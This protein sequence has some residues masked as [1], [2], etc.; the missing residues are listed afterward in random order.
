MFND[1]GEPLEAHPGAA[2]LVLKLSSTARI[3]CEVQDGYPILAITDGGIT[4]LLMPFGPSEGGRVAFCDN[5]IGSD[6]VLAASTYRNALA[7]AYAA[8]EGQSLPRRRPPRRP[9]ERQEAATVA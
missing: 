8:Q 2:E 3:G 1:G 6:F 5:S 4:V 7:E 9:R